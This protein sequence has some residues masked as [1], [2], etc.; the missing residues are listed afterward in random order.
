FVEVD[1][2]NLQL[3]ADA[4]ISSFDRDLDEDD[5]S[6][7]DDPG[8]EVDFD[9]VVLEAFAPCSPADI[10]GPYGAIT[11]T[12]VTTFIGLFDALDPAADVDGTPGV[13]FLDMVTQLNAVAA[14][15]P[16]E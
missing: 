2:T 16:S 1:Q 12:D 11:S 14:G 9:N 15:C 6:D 5:P 13:D 10:A 3:A 8:I 7:P 4:R